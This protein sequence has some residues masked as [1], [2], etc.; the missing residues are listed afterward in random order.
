MSGLQALGVQSLVWGAPELSCNIKQRL[1]Q[2]S[3]YNI[4]FLGVPFV[5]LV[6]HNSRRWMCGWMRVSMHGW[7]DA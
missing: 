5:T 3:T 2:A 4:P 7:M 1:F 6:K